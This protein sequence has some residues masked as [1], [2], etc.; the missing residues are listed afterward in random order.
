MNEEQ[1]FSIV[2]YDNGGIEIYAGDVVDV[3]PN[4]QGYYDKYTIRKNS[5]IEYIKCNETRIQ[6]IERNVTCLR[7]DAKPRL[8]I[9]ES[10]DMYRTI[11][12][13]TVTE[14]LSTT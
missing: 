1:T 13:D 4:P 3:N 12:G 14:R 9:Q 7:I 6:Y 11:D 5:I 10:S 2:Y 8:D